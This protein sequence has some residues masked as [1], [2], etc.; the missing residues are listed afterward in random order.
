[1]P[2]K[3]VSLLVCSFIAVQSACAVFMATDDADDSVYADY[4][5]F[6]NGLNAG[7][8]FEA[9]INGVDANM[10][11]INSQQL[12]G[13]HLWSIDGT[14]E[15]QRMFSSPSLPTGGTLTLSAMHQSGG[16]LQ[17]IDAAGSPL[18]D[19]TYGQY[20]DTD[21]F[22]FQD[23]FILTSGT[24]TEHISTGSNNFTGKRI[25]YT[26]DWDSSQSSY[27]FQSIT[28]W[29]SGGV[30]FTNSLSGTLALSSPVSGLGFVVSDDELLFDDISVAI[31]P[32]PSHL[33]AIAVLFGLLL[34]IRFRYRLHST[35]V[36][37]LMMCLLPSVLQAASWTN[38][39]GHVINATPL[40]QKGDKVIFRQQNNT[41]QVSLA[42]FPETEQARIKERLGQITVP[43]GF[44]AQYEFAVTTV[45]RSRLLFENQRISAEKHRI[46]VQQS[47]DI[48]NK[49]AQTLIAQKKLTQTR[50]A[51]ITARARS[52]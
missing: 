29:G 40:E 11:C 42:A 27:T 33:A 26:I 17:L 2:T 10:Y 18:L 31:V 34:C 43:D 21:T 9:W 32:E 12:N 47:I 22:S 5:Q 38:R 36:L 45:R 39:A 37:L 19:I 8:G 44:H 4:D 25:D 24:T 49:Q 7:S 46:N 20:F 14:Q 1:M 41:I 28:D 15:L 35:T 50:L 30:T 52:S 48:L 6:Y 51:Q 13:F 3:L 23:G 16:N